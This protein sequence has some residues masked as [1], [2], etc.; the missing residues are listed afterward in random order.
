MEIGDWEIDDNYIAFG[1][2]GAV[3]IYFIYEYVT[4][5]LFGI[6]KLFPY[7]GI[8]LGILGVIAYVYSK[9]ILG[10]D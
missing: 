1:I 2:I 6:V 8:I 9:Y 10:N 7:Y 3:V 5:G 4:V